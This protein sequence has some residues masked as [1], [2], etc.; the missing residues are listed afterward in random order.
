MRRRKRRGVVRP[1]LVAS[2]MHGATVH[3]L[4]PWARTKAPRRQLPDR[5]LATLL[6]REDEGPAISPAR[7]QLKTQFG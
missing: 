7:A 5:R 2:C 4:A 3:G 1:G 6:A